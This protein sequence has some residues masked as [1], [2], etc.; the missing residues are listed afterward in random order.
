MYILTGKNKILIC[1]FLIFL[2]IVLK[3]NVF[4]RTHVEP[5]RI[6]LYVKPGGR[7]TGVMKVIN[8]GDK[9]IEIKAFLYDW[10]LNKDDSLN[11][12]E[13]GSTDCSLDGLIKFNPRVFKLP[14][15]GKQIV[16]FTLTAP[17][18]IKREKRGIVFFEQETD[19]IE[20]N[21][22]AKVVTQIGTAIYLVPTTAVSN[23]KLLKTRIGVP[24]DKEETL[25]G[26]LVENDGAAHIRYTINY[27]VIN[28]KGA[29]IKENK[30][31]ELVILPGNKKTVFFPIAENLAPGKYKLLLKIDFYGTTKS[32]NYTIPFEGK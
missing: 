1:I 27:K 4:A 29:L 6:I 3:G 18:E 32:A 14:P 10:N 23:F 16:R 31:K 25:A 20:K 22:G 7:A 5:V 12:M 13:A 2:V 9:D 24:K 15:G 28:H 21:T 8:K 26:L 11:A 30:L 19:L 17:E